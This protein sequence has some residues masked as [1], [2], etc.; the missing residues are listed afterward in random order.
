MAN[1][2]VKVNTNVR[3]GNELQ[4]VGDMLAATQAH[5]VQVKNVM[6]NM[7]NGVDFVTLETNFGIPAG[8][9]SG[10]YNT[11][12]SA[13]AAM[14]GSSAIQTTINALGSITS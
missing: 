9:G 10:A 1:I 8:S 3:L 4:R 5:L 6:D 7:T 11:I 13:C 12:V 14:T 2:Y